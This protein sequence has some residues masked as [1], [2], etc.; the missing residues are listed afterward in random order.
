MANEPHAHQHGGTDVYDDCC[1]TVCPLCDGNGC[2]EG[3]GRCEMVHAGPEAHK[4][5]R[6]CGG[7]GEA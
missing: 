2:V 7:S 3:C 4:V 5:C 6:R 1:Q